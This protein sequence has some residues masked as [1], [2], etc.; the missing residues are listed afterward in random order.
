[1]PENKRKMEPSLPALLVAA[2]ALQMNCASIIFAHHTPQR[3][4]VAHM[5]VLRLSCL[6]MIFL[7]LQ[8]AK[9]T[10]EDVSLP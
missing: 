4:F 6:V 8:S 2:V 3:F 7:F 1:M 9:I 5:K 10:F